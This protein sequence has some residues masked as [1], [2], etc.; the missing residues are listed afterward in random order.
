[1]KTFELLVTVRP[2]HLDDLHHVN[3]VQYLAW[4]QQVSKAHWGTLTRPEWD[5][6]YIWVVR[7][8]HITYLHAAVL[9]DELSISTHVEQ[10]RGAQSE[11]HVQ[12]RLRGDKTPV[13]TCKTIWVL[14]D[15]GTGKPVR[16]PVEMVEALT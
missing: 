7:S 16:I 15:A 8:H 3:N 14:L 1:M 5:R 4:V 10:A 2:G 6:D 11:R 9:G 12:I 13:V